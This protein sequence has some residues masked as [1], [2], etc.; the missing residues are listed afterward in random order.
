L[1]VFLLFFYY[2]TSEAFAVQQVSQVEVRLSKCL[3]NLDR[4][5]ALCDQDSLYDEL[6]FSRSHSDRMATATSRLIELSTFLEGFP[7]PHDPDSVAFLPYL[8]TA[9]NCISSILS[10]QEKSPVFIS[11]SRMV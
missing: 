5:R 8:G 10:H 2:F 7:C 6:G 9:F 4:A 11:Q 3:E 1:Q